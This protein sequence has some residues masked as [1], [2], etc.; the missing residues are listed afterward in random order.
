MWQIFYETNEYQGCTDIA[1]R[2][3]KLAEKDTCLEK[4]GSEP[5]GGKQVLERV[6]GGGRKAIG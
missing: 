3:L 5:A 6:A 4:M 1:Q 2:S